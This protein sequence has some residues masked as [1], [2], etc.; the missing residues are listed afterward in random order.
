M[1]S[2]LAD[3]LQAVET[4]IQ[5]AVSNSGRVA[6]DVALL[7]VSKS[8]DLETSADLARLLAE[9]RPVTL[10]ENRVD[11]LESKLEAFAALD[12]P[13]IAW[14]FIGHLQRNKARRV[15][16]S[17]AVLHSVHSLRLLEALQRLAEEED[18]RLEIFLQM[19]L[20][21]ESEKK[22]MKEA[23]LLDCMQVMPDLSR[24]DLA[25]LMA[26]GP[27]PDSNTP[28]RDVFARA[29]ALA[30]ALET[31]HRALFVRERCELS[32][33]MSHDLEDAIAAGS[34]WLRVGSA[35]F[36]PREPQDQAV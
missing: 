28:A 2:T 31:E 5:S 30:H 14:H 27:R 23:E 6:G 18:T 35:L 7:P 21:G 19:G 33:G 25:G 17:C 9:T 10:A 16:R 11:V 29:A 22:G 1:L 24:L 36:T 20:T 34:H 15:V 26:M 13:P 32:M 4:R 12:L 3:N 8:A